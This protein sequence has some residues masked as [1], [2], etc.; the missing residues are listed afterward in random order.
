MNTTQTTDHSTT[1]SQNPYT[2][3]QILEALRS[4]EAFGRFTFKPDKREDELGHKGYYSG[5]GFA[6]CV[7]RALIEE[8]KNAKR[9]R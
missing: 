9:S 4:W 6:A 2:K 1:A 3:D 5:G 8:M 7:L